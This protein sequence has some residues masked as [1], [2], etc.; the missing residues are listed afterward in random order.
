MLIFNIFLDFDNRHYAST[1]CFEVGLI[2]L[3]G[4]PMLQNTYNIWI[5]VYEAESTSSSTAYIMDHSLTHQRPV[6]RNNSN[7]CTHVVPKAG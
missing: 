4:T 7:M 1:Y 2:Y 6:G 3:L 5:F